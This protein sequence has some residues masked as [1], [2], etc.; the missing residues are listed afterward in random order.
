MI[1]VVYSVTSAGTIHNLFEA[2]WFHCNGKFVFILLAKI[3]N[4]EP[5][6]TVVGRSVPLTFCSS[7]WTG[8][9]FREFT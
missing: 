2:I 3:V 5:F 6:T 8:K 4:G 7:C 1:S 9:T